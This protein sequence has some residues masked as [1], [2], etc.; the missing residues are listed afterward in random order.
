[1]HTSPLTRHDHHPTHT[2][3][4]RWSAGQHHSIAATATGHLYTW[5]DNTY[6]QLGMD[7]PWQLA[8]T[9]PVPQA[10]RSRPKGPPT[11]HNA[12][13]PAQPTPLQ[14]LRPG[15]PDSAAAQ[16][17]L[18]TAED[19]AAT[20]A[21]RYKLPDSLVAAFR[22]Q[23]PAEPHRRSFANRQGGAG[24]R[25]SASQQHT[26]NGTALQVRSCGRCSRS[27]ALQHPCSGKALRA[28]CV[29]VL[30]EAAPAAAQ[31]ERYRH[32]LSGTPPCQ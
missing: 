14:R 27:K 12:P 23:P 26:G 1:M 6:D 16:A 5:G 4:P 8:M 31:L 17:V 21:R 19:E 3:S 2:A 28:A 24:E 18:H 20:L 9:V 13:A 32:R 30:S 29:A 15:S 22:E 11:P 25:R 10:A 7:G